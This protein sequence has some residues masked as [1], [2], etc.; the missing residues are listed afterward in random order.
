MFF[1]QQLLLDT[2]QDAAYKIP[3]F[4]I[5]AHQPTGSPVPENTLLVLNR[6]KLGHLIQYSPLDTNTS[7]QLIQ[8][9]EFYIQAFDENLG[10]VKAYVQNPPSW[11][12][13]DAEEQRA[14]LAQKVLV[15]V[16]EKMM[17][18]ISDDFNVT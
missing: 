11:L 13:R 18:E 1:V 5:F 10:L 7:S 2:Y 8:H 6:T 12:Q 16:Y 3:V 15:Q 9:L 14:E 17:L 4:Q